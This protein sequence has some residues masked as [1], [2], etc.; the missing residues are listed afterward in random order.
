MIRGMFLPEPPRSA[1]ADAAYEEDLTNDGYVF[2]NTRLWAYRP[3]VNLAF[4]QLRSML[5]RGSTLSE[6]EVAVLVTA[7]ASRRADSYCALAW[8]KKLAGLAGDATAAAVITGA[9]DPVLS[10]REAALADWARAVV[11]DPNATTAEDVER[12]RAAGLSDQEIFEVTTFIA[13]RLAFSTVDNAL[14]AE[15]DQRLAEGA[16]R[17]VRDAVTFGRP[18]AEIPS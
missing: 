13:F 11:A 2:N 1:G 3:D 17:A 16:P 7:T 14:G 12:L 6:R 15:P 9:N 8:G 5:T 4:V 10:E 18:A